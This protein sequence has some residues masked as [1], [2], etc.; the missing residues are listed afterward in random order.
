VDRRASEHPFSPALLAVSGGLTLA[1]AVAAVPLEMHAWD[2][3]DRYTAQAQGGAAIATADRQAFA[4]ARTW[5]YATV[6]TAIGMAALTAGLAAWY[7]FGTSPR[8]VIVT[9]AGVSG[10]F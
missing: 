7:F 3:H 2:L 9:P 6:G 4:D 1:A 5:A 10:R 8:E